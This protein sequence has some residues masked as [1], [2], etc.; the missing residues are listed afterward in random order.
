[1]EEWFEGDMFYMQSLLTKQEQRRYDFM[2][3]LSDTNHW[4]ILPD[5]AK[6]LNCSS[7]I[8]KDDIQ[9]LNKHFD[10][11]T[12]QTSTRGVRI[13]YST[14]RG[15]KTFCQKMLEYSNAYTVL[16]MIFLHSNQTVQDL[17]DKLFMST[18]T[19]Y[20]LIDQINSTLKKSNQFYIETNPCQIVGD[21]KEIRYFF[22]LYFFEKYSHFNFPLGDFNYE[23][24]DSFLKALLEASP[25]YIDFSFY[26]VTKIVTIVNLIRYKDKHY[27][28]VDKSALSKPRLADNF[29][30]YSVLFKPFEDQLHMDINSDFIAQVFTPYIQEGMSDTYEEFVE[31][32]KKNPIF[33]DNVNFLRGLLDYIAQKNYLQLE[34]REEVV[35]GMFNSLHL[36][37]QDPQSDYILYNRNQRFTKDIAQEFPYFYKDLYYWLKSF[38]EK[39]EM[40]MTEEGI[41]FYIYNIFATWKNLVPQLRRKIAKIRTL[42]ISDR[43]KAHAEMIKGFIEYEFSE[44][45]TVDFFIE[46]DLNQTVLEALD[47]DLIVTTFPVADL[48]K[49]RYVYIPNVPKYTDYEKIQRQIDKINAERMDEMDRS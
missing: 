7:R 6:Q 25:I 45:I 35:F 26:N 9:Y 38:R 32:T 11:F 22:Y 24:I 31:K 36:E 49:N 48:E 15:F 2:N 5:I 29:D 47:Y 23:A 27:I 34:N 42:V 28:E 14:N 16:E 33:G 41:A 12:I 21:E 1:M 20:R 8:L 30:E 19:L 17:A 13:E 37:G 10:D 43:H 39:L 40:P 18:S 3:I 46:K 4:I 44:Q